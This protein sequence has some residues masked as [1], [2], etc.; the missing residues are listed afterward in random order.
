MQESGGRRIKRA[1]YIDVHSIKL[2]DN[3]MLERFSK[4]RYI[5][6]YI[7][8]K[9]NE[10]RAYHRDY[11]IDES[12]LLNSRRL[13]N[14]GTFRAYLEAYLRKHPDINQELTLMVRQLPPNELGLPLEIY[15]FSAQKEWVRYEKVQADIFD[16]VMAMLDLFDLRAYQRDGHLSLLAHR[17]QSTY[18][19]SP[20][21]DNAPEDAQEKSEPNR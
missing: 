20:E 2:C 13:T 1:I 8:K 15:C 18:R 17:E 9:K 6:E 5:N 19:N 4:I 21:S 11:S 7:D 14:I 16:H 10:L 3:D 12:D